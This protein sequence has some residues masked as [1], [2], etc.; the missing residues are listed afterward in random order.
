MPTERAAIDFDRLLKL[1]LVVARFGEMDGARWWNTNGLLSRRGAVLMSRGFPK[2]HRFAQ[3]RV[4]FAVARARCD[5]VFNLPGSVTLWN[6]PAELEDQFD[7]RWEHWLDDLESWEELFKSLE[8]LPKDDLL[9]CLRRFEL[10]G[11]EQKEPLTKL[12]RSAEKLAVP[13]PG[14]R[15]LDDQA[16]TLLAA[17]FFR[18]EVGKPAIPYAK[19]EA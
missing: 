14:V 16:L 19:L 5:E 18:G 11:D 12:R 7:A 17:G 13:V 8:S 1:R 15:E 9:E 3:A 6:L 4:V 2:T 10:I